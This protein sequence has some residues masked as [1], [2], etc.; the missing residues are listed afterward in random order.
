MQCKMHCKMLCK[1]PF[2][3][4]N[5]VQIESQISRKEEEKIINLKREKQEITKP[6]H[7]RESSEIVKERTESHD[8]I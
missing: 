6:I 3:M 8:P 2:K 4:Q 5:A 1:M 7:L